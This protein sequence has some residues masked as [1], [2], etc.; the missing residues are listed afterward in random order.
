MSKAYLMLWIY[1]KNVS[2]SNYFSFWMSETYRLKNFFGMFQE[3]HQVV[4]V[5]YLKKYILNMHELQLFNSNI[6]M[7]YMSQWF[8]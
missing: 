2:A 6:L 5:I 7:V 8:H 4:L 1:T 3:M